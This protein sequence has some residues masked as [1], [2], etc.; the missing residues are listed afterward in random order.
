[1]KMKYL[2]LMSHIKMIKKNIKLYTAF[3]EDM[4][5]SGS[6]VFTSLVLQ[7]NIALSNLFPTVLQ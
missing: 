6:C 3:K 7:S 2:S 5:S 4:K 1:M